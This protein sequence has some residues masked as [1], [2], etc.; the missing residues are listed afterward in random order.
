MTRNAVA[1]VLAG[2][3]WN[4]T[5]GAAEPSV[6]ATLRAR[7]TEAYNAGDVAALA[8]LYAADARIQEGYCPAVVGREAIASYW[9]SDLGSGATTHLGVD[10]TFSA[11]DLVYL[12]GKYSVEFEQGGKSLVGTYLQIWRHSAEAGWTIHRET[13][14]NLACAKIVID[15]RTQETEI[16]Q[17]ADTAV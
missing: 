17:T 14:T 4:M 11:G 13:W 9:H 8:A 16:V 5:C 10:D 7:W 2:V 15:P 3:V 1:C 6:E 12:S